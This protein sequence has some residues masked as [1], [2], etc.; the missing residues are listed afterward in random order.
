LH[1]SVAEI[2]ADIRNQVEG[3][4]LQSKHELETLGQQLLVRFSCSALVMFYLILAVLHSFL[5]IIFVF[6][7]A[8]KAASGT[9]RS[10]IT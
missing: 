7:S 6:C 5:F 4:M 1:K 3:F 10:A 2:E 8:S 9:A